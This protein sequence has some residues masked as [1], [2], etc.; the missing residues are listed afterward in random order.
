MGTD[1]TDGGQ[2][3]ELRCEAIAP[4]LWRVSWAAGGTVDG[5]LYQR[6]PTEADDATVAHTTGG[7]TSDGVDIGDA[8]RI[9]GACTWQLSDKAFTAFEFSRDLGRCARLRD[10]FDNS[11]LSGNGNLGEF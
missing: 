5:I 4:W 7:R 10:R 8:N 1:E 3:L 9:A 2:P 11:I 6:S